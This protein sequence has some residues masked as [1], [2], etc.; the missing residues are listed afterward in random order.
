MSKQ[1]TESQEEEQPLTSEDWNFTGIPQEELWIAEIWEYCREIK[2][3][4]EA[5]NNWLEQP[6]LIYLGSYTNP[7][8]SSEDDYEQT[9]KTVRESLL[10]HKLPCEHS[11]MKV[12]YSDLVDVAPTNV[13]CHSLIRIT[14]LLGKWPAPYKITRSAPN[15]EHNLASVLNQLSE[16]QPV[17]WAKKKDFSRHPSQDSFIATVVIN[18]R[19]TKK[20]LQKC[21][22]EMCAP[23]LSAKRGRKEKLTPPLVRLKQLAALRLFKRVVAPS[24]Q[25]L[26]FEKL[27]I[28][29][30]RLDPKNEN[31]ILPSYANAKGFKAAAKEADKY[32]LN[33]KK[34]TKFPW[35]PVDDGPYTVF[36]E[37]EKLAD[38]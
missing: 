12:D 14:P 28:E 20:N 24:K 25:V 5:F 22:A 10:Q 19:A 31:K 8:G 6:V 38:F 32:L 1:R 30:Q 23:L 36:G 3:V 21:F 34:Y 26:S 7:D 37:P 2:I 27:E 11:S 13:A 9:G 16:E 35:V 17:R 18:R 4:R 15:F 33:Y 29:L